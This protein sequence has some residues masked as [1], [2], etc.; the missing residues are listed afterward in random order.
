SSDLAWIREIHAGRATTFDSAT[1]R[2]ARD[3]GS[4]HGPLAGRR[5]RGWQAQSTPAFPGAAP[6]GEHGCA[7][8]WRDA[9][10]ARRGFAG[11][12]WR[13][14]LGRATRVLTAGA[15]LAPATAGDR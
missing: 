15:R 13:S 3:A 8:R 9:A 14:F 6:L 2:S 11:P 4:Q 1:A 7:C 12:P 5:T 10:E